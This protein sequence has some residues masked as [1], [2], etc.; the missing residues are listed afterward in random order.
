MRRSPLLAMVPILT[1]SNVP[2]Q[3]EEGLGHRIVTAADH[4]R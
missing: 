1:T 2:E 4:D 3:K